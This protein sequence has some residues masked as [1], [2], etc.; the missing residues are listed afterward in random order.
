[1]NEGKIVNQKRHGLIKYLEYSL[2][3]LYSE[4]SDR[5]DDIKVLKDRIDNLKSEVL[6]GVKIRGKMNDQMHGEKF[7]LT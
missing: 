6:E 5:Y 1:M 2:H 4:Q 7:L 3:F